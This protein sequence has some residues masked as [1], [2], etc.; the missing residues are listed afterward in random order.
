MNYNNNTRYFTK[1]NV[2]KFSIACWVAV[3]A[4]LLVYFALGWPWAYFGAAFAIIA[5]IAAIATSTMSV[6]DKEYTASVVNA[7]NTFMKD[8]RA[9]TEEKLNAHNGRGKAPVTLDDEQIKFARAYLL[10]GQI[11]FRVGHDGRH[12]SNKLVMTAYYADKTAVYLGYRL[13]TMTA[14]E[15]EEIFAVYPY[16]SVESISASHPEDRPSFAEYDTVTLKLKN[17]AEPVVFHMTK[18][19]ELDNLV[20]QVSSRITVDEE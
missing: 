17:K 9:F 3:A 16:S 11:M 13:L 15:C 20:K 10:E 19:I 2:G 4:G 1:E 7:E 8:F 6:S 12:R 14:D 18:D 5:V